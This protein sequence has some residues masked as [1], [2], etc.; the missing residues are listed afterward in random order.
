VGFTLLVGFLYTFS[1]HTPIFGLW[2]LI[3]RLQRSSETTTF[4]PLGW[5]GSI[6]AHQNFLV[7]DLDHTDGEWVC[8]ELHLASIT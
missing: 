8:I 4:F 3:I 5:L 7:F 6:R 2:G 1:F